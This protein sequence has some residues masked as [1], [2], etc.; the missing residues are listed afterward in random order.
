M[1][2]PTRTSGLSAIELADYTRSVLDIAM[3]LAEVMF[4]NGAGAEDVVAAVLAITRAYGVRNVDADVTYSVIELSYENPSTHETITRTR[5]VRYRTLDYHTLS[6][7]AALIGELVEKPVDVAEARR[8]IARI[9]SSPALYPRMLRRFGWSL[10]GAGAAFLIGGNW[11]VAVAALLATMGIDYLTTALANRRV[12]VFFQTLAGGAVGPLVA[13]LVH[14]ID[15]ASN[16]SLVVVATIIMLLAGVTTFGAVHDALSGF[17]VTGTA[18]FVEATI[19]TGGLVAGVAASSL[20]LAHFGLVLEINPASSPT[21]G[22]LPVQLAASVLI[23]LGFAFAVQVPKRALWAVCLLGASAELFYVLALGAQTGSVFGSALAA[24]GVGLLAA[25]VSRLVRVP[26]LVIVVSA[27]VPLVPG[28][29]LF[30]GLLQLSEG[31]MD[32]LLSMLAAAAV[33]VALAAGAILGQYLVQAAWG[34][35]RALPRRFVG[36][37]MALPVKLNR[38]ART[39][40]KKF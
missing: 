12:P 39:R 2:V 40:T 19:I 7:A 8:E 16:S 36:P 29:L 4:G 28:L 35:A 14:L 37:L 9:V 1:S 6:R 33:A 21:L 27:L 25:A 11:L 23:V 3:R 13:A 17:Y 30:S 5:N 34:P 20:M 15:P 32:G 31:S 24:I 22:T 18:R 38:T 10:V 26:P